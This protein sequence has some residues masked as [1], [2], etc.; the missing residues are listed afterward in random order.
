VTPP[1]PLVR[2]RGLT[3]GFPGRNGGWKPRLEAIDLT[4]ESTERVGLIG[5][6]GSGKSLTA[7]A[8][9]GLVPPPG[10]IIAGQVIVNGTD[11]LK[12]PAEK[13]RRIRGGV[14]GLVFQE[15][16]TAL[17]PV[18]TVAS[19]L[20]EAFATD[21]RDDDRRWRSRAAAALTEVGLDPHHTLSRYA[22]QLSGGQR[23]RVILALAM[24]R[25]P[26]LLVADEPTSSLDL[27]TQSRVLQTIDEISSRRRAALLLISH[28]LAVVASA[29][30]RVVVMLAG[31]IVE[32]APTD[33]LLGDPLHPLTR[34][35]VSAASGEATA[36]D[37]TPPAAVA[38]G[39]RY[40]PACP[41]AVAGCR[42]A[43]PAL[44]GADDGR[45]V[46]CPV[47]LNGGNR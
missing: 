12:L 43:E 15:A 44:L 9:M 8:L 5:L 17:N 28:D 45:R 27:L 35:I 21:R 22:H 29:V 31:R 25:E 11:V 14:V 34:A 19:H 6:S 40:A 32:E 30:D 41:L 37:P 4:I 38:A 10:R 47:V 20:R 46:R 33:Q 13:R 36:G 23:Q 2:L 18:L 1:S 39:C 24:A 3:V 7:L 16:E 42:K 26:A